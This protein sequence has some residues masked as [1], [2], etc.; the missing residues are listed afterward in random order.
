M[1]FYEIVKFYRD[2]I[3]YLFDKLLEMIKDLFSR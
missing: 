1:D 3:V 2:D